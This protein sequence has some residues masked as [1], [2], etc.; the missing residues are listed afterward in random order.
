MHAMTEANMSSPAPQ[1]STDAM[2]LT[3][4]AVIFGGSASGLWILDRLRRAGYRALLIEADRLGQ[5][6]T[7]ACQGII[8]G[9]LKYSLDGRLTASAKAIRSMPAVWR[10][11]LDG[12]RAP[13]LGASVLRA[14]CCHLWH[15]GG[16]SG[17]LGLLGARQGLRI[18]PVPLARRDWPQGLEAV[19]GEVCRLDEQV[20]APRALVAALAA[21]HAD[22][23]LRVPPEALTI[24]RH[25][26]GQPRMALDPIPAEAVGA[27]PLV[28]APRVVVLAAGIGNAALRTRW[29]LPAELMQV[30]SVQM[31]LARGDLPV[32][33]GHCIEGASVALTITSA[34]DRAGRGIWQIGGGL[35]E[36]G[37]D[38]DTETFVHRGRRLVEQ[39]LGRSLP[40]TEWS[41]YRAD[42]AEVTT[43]AGRR[44]DDAFALREGALIT[45]WP[46]KLALVP[47][48]AERV[49]A[50]ARPLLDAPP[51][52]A[53]GDPWR[54]RDWPAPELA[55][56]PWERASQWTSAH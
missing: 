55:P 28:L 40:G 54:P 33:N 44:P 53:A 13:A 47:R 22:G 18:K 38:L 56:P 7:A 30:R 19:G 15:G 43:A 32:L 2:L 26:D 4:D 25:G 23:L 3:P 10:A 34:R 17:H 21:P 5:G 11:C 1:A 49:L 42:K 36:D 8:H 51:R 31:L 46:T 37:V 14:P 20:I 16:L 27:R 50:L 29:G 48:L 52:P 6:Q 45:A 9:G 24:E 41:A 12:T 39:A 35:S